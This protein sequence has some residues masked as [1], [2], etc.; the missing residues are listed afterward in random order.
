MGSS[1]ARYARYAV[2]AA[3]VIAGG[4]LAGATAGEV[5]QVWLV[6]PTPPEVIRDV[7]IRN[8]ADE[9]GHRASFRILLFSDEFRW[10]INSF[11]SLEEAG[12]RPQFT[13]EMKAVLNSASEIIC[14]GASS[15]EIPS[16]VSFSQGRVQEE[17]R[18][19]RRAEKIAVWVREALNR[20]IPVRKLNVGHHA[21]TGIDDTS[22]Q[23]RVVIILVLDH[24]DGAN[25]DQSLRKAMA[26]E[27]VRAPIFEAL[28]TRYSLGGAESFTWVP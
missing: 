20:P 12:K 14:V 11:D 1:I 8:V 18:A 9:Q 6:V 3:W 25:I 27:S 5:R 19:A 2:T 13:T 4:W 16:G 22:D 28:L 7:V 24:D 26:G 23:R 17:H 10:R 21:P 15:E